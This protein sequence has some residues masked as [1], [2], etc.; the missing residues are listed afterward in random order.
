MELRTFPLLAIASCGYVLIAM[1]FIGPEIDFVLHQGW[2][3]AP[4]QDIKQHPH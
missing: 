3:L 1:G 4:D 2:R